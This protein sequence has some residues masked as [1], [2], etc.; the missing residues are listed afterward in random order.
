MTTLK[1]KLPRIPSPI[2]EMIVEN[3]ASDVPVTRNALKDSDIEN[4]FFW[5]TAKYMPDYEFWYYIN[6]EIQLMP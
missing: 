6:E 4:S 1:Q 2:R 5:G 3:I